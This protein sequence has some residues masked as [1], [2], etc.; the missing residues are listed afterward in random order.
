MIVLSSSAPSACSPS[1]RSSI[2]AVSSSSIRSLPP[3]RHLRQRCFDLR[4][5]SPAVRNP[6]HQDLRIHQ[7][8]HASHNRTEMPRRIIYTLGLRRSWFSLGTS[9]C[10]SSPYSRGLLSRRA[11]EPYS[12]PTADTENTA[13]A[14][15]LWTS[16]QSSPEQSI[17]KH[18]C[19]PGA[20]HKGPFWEIEMYASS[21]S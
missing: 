17:N 12:P 15:T 14:D 18:I 8:S 5:P 3:R 4:S 19:D 11:D 13:W 10:W 20:S 9:R 2:P 1:T 6:A 7:S 21:E 16:S